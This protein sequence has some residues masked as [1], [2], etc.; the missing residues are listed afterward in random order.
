VLGRYVEPV[1]VALDGVEQS[2]SWVVEFSQQARGGAGCLVAVEYLLQGLDGV[3]GAMVSG[4]MSVCG[5]P[6]PTT[7]RYK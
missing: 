1:G 4:R 5:S 3:R 6:S 7:C 2:G